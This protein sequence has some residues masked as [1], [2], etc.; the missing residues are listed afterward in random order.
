MMSEQ[1]VGRITD[2]EWKENRNSDCSIED[3]DLI[4]SLLVIYKEKGKHWQK[5]PTR[6]LLEAIKKNQVCGRVSW[7][8]VVREMN[9]I[10]KEQ[11]MARY[12][13]LLRKQKKDEMFLIEIRQLQMSR[14]LTS[15]KGIA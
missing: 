14:W 8:N 7:E 15:G 5:N 4:N 13:Y 12:Y 3:D 1:A 6:K 11:A 9:G 10:T 2:L